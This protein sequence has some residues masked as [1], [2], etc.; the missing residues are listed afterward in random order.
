MSEDYHLRSYESQLRIAL[1]TREDFDHFLLAH[2]NCKSLKEKIE[3][4][5]FLVEEAKAEFKDYT[6]H[7]QELVKLK[8][9]WAKHVL[10]YTNLAQSMKI[11]LEFA[12]QDVKDDAE[13]KRFRKYLI[14]LQ[15]NENPFEI[16]SSIKSPTNAS[17]IPSSS[18]R[19]PPSISR[20][21]LPKSKFPAA[22]LLPGPSSKMTGSPSRIPATSRPPTSN[23][24]PPTQLP[25]KSLTGNNS[26]KVQEDI[27]KHKLKAQQAKEI[28]KMGSFGNLTRDIEIRQQPKLIPRAEVIE[29]QEG[30]KVILDGLKT[31]GSV[32][33]RSARPIAQSSCKSYNV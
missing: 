7:E 24:T 5:E 10:A 32:K 26:L 20:M 28:H 15:N 19:R 29:R 3:H 22:S 17:N 11:T 2:H 31:V 1:K 6:K 9:N 33:K 12:I 30:L 16:S 8:R 4:E 21:P 13:N 23:M 18:S 27:K 14:F 25:K